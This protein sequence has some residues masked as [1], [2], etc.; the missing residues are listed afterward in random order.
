L[1]LHTRAGRQWVCSHLVDLGNEMLVTSVTRAP[2]GLQYKATVGK[3]PPWHLHTIMHGSHAHMHAHAHTA[4]GGG[5]FAQQAALAP[6][7]SQQE[8]CGHCRQLCTP[9]PTCR[10]LA[11]QAALEPRPGQQHLQHPC[12]LCCQLVSG[13]QQQGLGRRRPS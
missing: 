11:E 2:Q 10:L 9:T 8:T 7:P 1:A 5:A 6:L 13:A 4:H 12:C 3:A